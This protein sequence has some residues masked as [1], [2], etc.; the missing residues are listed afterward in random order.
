MNYKFLALLLAVFALINTGLSL[1]FNLMPVKSTAYRGDNLEYLLRLK[2]NEQSQVSIYINKFAVDSALGVATIISP[3][4][5]IQL[6]PGEELAVNIT[7]PLSEL[8][9]SGMYIVPLYLTHGS[10]TESLELRATIL[11]STDIAM[12]TNLKINSPS[13]IDP[14]IQ[15]S[16]NGSITSSDSAYPVLTIIISNDKGIIFNHSSLQQVKIGVNQFDRV[17]RL[18]P[19]SP[20]GDYTLLVQF[21]FSNRVVSQLGAALTIPPYSSLINDSLVSESFLGKSI[22]IPVFNNGTSYEEVELNYALSTMES[23]LLSNAVLIINEDGRTVNATR[24]S[25]SNNIVS[26]GNL[27]LNPGQSAELLIEVTYLPL[28]IIPFALLL[29]IISWL[30]LTRNL[31]VEKEVS[32]AYSTE[33]TAYVKISIKLK[34]IS[35]KKLKN[36]RIIEPLPVYVKGIGEFGSI[37]GLVD[38]KKREVT[39]QSEMLKPKEELR[40]TYK[41]KTGVELLGDVMLPP[42]VVKYS[43]KRRVLEA[44]SNTPVFMI[45][46]ER[47]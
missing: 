46:G 42:A 32:E 43:V 25:I 47:K 27:I 16:I 33:G 34:N 20:S 1:E 8:T 13:I 38:K 9:L 28:I 17:I 29:I 10:L 45:K 41:F 12:L 11:E 31:I 24:P 15:F 23:L 44:K 39:W 5:N 30:F 35:L 37:K 7:I 4:H 3:S 26:S 6:M 22:S 18:N 36:L 19:R 14:R 21:S 2:N 40:I